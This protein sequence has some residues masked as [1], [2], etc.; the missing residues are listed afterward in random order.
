MSKAKYWLQKAKEEN[1]AIG[2][3]NAASIETLKAIVTAAKNQQSPVII[4]SSHK[5]V[6]Y[7]GVRELVGVVRALEQSHG[8]PIILNLDHSP[9]FDSCKTAIES[10]FDYV[11]FDGGQLPIEENIQIAKEVVKLAHAH[12][13]LVEG[14]MDHIE[15]SS[16]DHRKDTEGYRQQ[17]S[18]FS[19]FT[20]P[21]N[22]L[23]FVNNTSVD[24]FAS[25]VG[26]RHG[27]YP[28]PKRI[29]LDLLKKIHETIPNTF[30]SLHG[31]SGIPESD[32]K[33][34]IK[35]GIV[36]ININSELRVAFHDKLKEI[37]MG[38]EGDEVAIYKIM[39]S[40]IDAMRIIVENKIQLFGSNN[41][42]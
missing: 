17:M 22:A 37:L 1:F 21:E 25:F 13:V 27:L 7:F 20:N 28:G 35:L 24:T 36:K 19:G 5:E 42:L 39:P 38:P 40:A 4:E 41:K 18:D 33:S 31:G 29:N 30:L 16:A 9:S 23:N 3:F 34:A 15:G 10:G 12:D 11:H 26:N 6:E 2:A 14:E 32:I 8:I